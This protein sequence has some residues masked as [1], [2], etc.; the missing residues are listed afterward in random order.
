VDE[1][2]VDVAFVGGGCFVSKVSI[3]D[4]MCFLRWGGM[5]REPLMP[6]LLMVGRTG[7]RG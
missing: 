1:V 3:W 7:E 2:G 6:V 5:D 4:S